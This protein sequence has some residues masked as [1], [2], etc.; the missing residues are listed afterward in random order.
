MKSIYVIGHKNPDTDSICSAIAYARLKNRCSSDGDYRPMR[1]G[2]INEE[3]AYVLDRFEA[4][5]PPLLET[6]EP[7]TSD[8]PYQ[9]SPGISGEASLLQAWEQM[10]REELNTLAV[11]RHGKLLGIVTLGDLAQSYWMEL[12]ALTRAGTRYEN[13]A[14]TLSGK[15]VCGDGKRRLSGERVVMYTPGSN[16]RGNLVLVG[17]EAAAQLAVLDAG[18]A[19]VILCET[20]QPEAQVLQRAAKKEIPLITTPLDLYTAARMLGQAVPVSAIMKTEGIVTC[21]EDDFVEELRTTMTRRRF[22]CYPVLDG[23]GRYSGMV[24]QRH[25]LQVEPRQVILVDHNERT[26]AVDGVLSAEILEIIDHHRL[27]SIETIQPV[28]FRN[29]PLGCTSTILNQMYHEQGV[30]PD[31]QTAGL[32]LSAILSDTLMFRSPTCTPA[33][34]AAAKE[35]AELAGVDYEELAIAMFNAGS[36]LEQRSEQEL[37]DRDCKVFVCDG[38]EFAA[39]QVSSVSPEAL[40]AVQK[41]MEEYLEVVRRRRHLDFTLFLLTDILDES[42]VLLFSG[43]EAQSVVETAFGATHGKQALRVPGLLSRK[44][45]LVPAVM[46]AIRQLQNP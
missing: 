28:F 12:D 37:F 16:L 45:Q 44:K 43:P 27:G 3:T 26:Q 5:V 2:R 41:R 24:T 11:V 14:E 13:L 1:A 34:E 9:R 40:L 25:L 7:R 31:P 33:D 18:A 32:M 23:D 36:D 21:Y 35:L 38:V 10:R 30:T 29:Q 22:R 19:G 6:L 4:D 8:V 39:G 46:Q 42:S 15:V 17:R 20:G